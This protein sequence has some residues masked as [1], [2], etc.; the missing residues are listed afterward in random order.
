MTNILH[1]DE[2]KIYEDPRKVNKWFNVQASARDV[3]Y[4]YVNSGSVTII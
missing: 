2:T 1:E 4:T 3:K